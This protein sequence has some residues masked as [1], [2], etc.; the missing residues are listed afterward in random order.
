MC[1]AQGCFSEECAA[2][3]EPFSDSGGW[4]ADYA[5]SMTRA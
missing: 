5:R 3:P 4:Q 1:I 2:I